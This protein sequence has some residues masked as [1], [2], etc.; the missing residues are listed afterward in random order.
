MANNRIE[1]VGINI[2]EK[3]TAVF[4]AFSHLIITFDPEMRLLC[5]TSR[6]NPGNCSYFRNVVAAFIT[7]PRSVC[8]PFLFILVV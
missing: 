8:L 5:F 2:A 4:F 6:E 1:S 3:A 7:I